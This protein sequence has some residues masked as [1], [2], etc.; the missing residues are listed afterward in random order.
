M[1]NENFYC[2]INYTVMTQPVITN[3]GHTFEEASLEAWLQIRPECPL[4]RTPIALGLPLDKHW[5]LQRKIG[6]FFAAHPGV[7]RPKGIGRYQWVAS[8]LKNLGNQIL[9][10][11]RL[12]IADKEVWCLEDGMMIIGPPNYLI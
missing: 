4:C 3:C 7:E 11:H 9:F 1:I 2:P 10:A 5:L 6:R 12:P 8:A